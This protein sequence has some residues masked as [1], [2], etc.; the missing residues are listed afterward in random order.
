MTLSLVVKV[1][2]EGAVLAVLVAV[3]CALFPRLRPAH[4]ALLWWM[5]SAKLL[6]GLLPFPAVPIAA[7]PATTVASSAPAA[8]LEASVDSTP[9]P[10]EALVSGSSRSLVAASIWLT[11]AIALALMAIPSWLSVRRLVGR[12]RPLDDDAS[13]LAIARACASAGLRRAP[14]V[15]SVAGLDAPMVAGLLRPA[16]LLPADGLSRLAPG[17]L[18]MTLAHEMAHVA[19]GD[20]W[21][22]LVPA[23]ARRLFFFHPA[24][25]IA[26]REHAIA[27]EAACDE[28]VLGR[29]G[30][31]AFVYGRLL[32]RAATRRAAATA[33][34][35]SPHSMLRRR[36]E[37]IESTLRRAP[38]GRAGWAV[39]ALAALAFVPVRLLA[40]DSDE[41]R[42][43][44][45]GSSKDNAYVVTEGRSHSSCGDVDDIRMADR[46]RQGGRDVVWFRLGDQDW[47]VRDPAVVAEA[48]RLFQR[49]GEIGAQQSEVGAKQSRI[50]EE[51]S[52]IGGEQ[53]E[54]GQRQ[55]KAALEQAEVELRRAE[56]DLVRDQTERAA[57]RVAQERLEK[58]LAEKELEAARAKS[59]NEDVRSAK[60]LDA[61]MK[62]L[63][64]RMEALGRQQEVFGEQQRA[65]GDRMQREIAE[66]Q[67]ALSEL[68][69]R[70]MREGKALKVD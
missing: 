54:I 43:L 2:L 29:P 55:A 5:V 8:P 40:R 25:W 57:D 42:C 48:Q 22:G 62:A 1:V 17:E 52:K 64:D 53:G 70:A 69:E 12:G 63:S 24:A 66:A 4:R 30:A 36:L 27:R 20:L 46:E 13:N 32:L 23:I 14:R 44:D 16:V 31:D 45:I 50:G 3:L 34:P 11:L 38:I 21:L 67:R 19:R 39:V 9:P 37:M 49:V 18:E 7:L 51:Q 68:L 47:V 15:L 6:F 60:E 33:I 56:Q 58:E 35:M 59:A 26:E 28:I 10:A 65:L 41:P 61:R